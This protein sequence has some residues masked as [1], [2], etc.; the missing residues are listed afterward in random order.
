M[1]LARLRKLVT[2]KAQVKIDSTY[3]QSHEIDVGTSDRAVILLSMGHYISTIIGCV[4]PVLSAS[5]FY[6]TS[7]STRVLVGTY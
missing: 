2:N 3:S 7:S 4:V 5:R 1:F 6:C